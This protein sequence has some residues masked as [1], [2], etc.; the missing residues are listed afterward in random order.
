MIHIK[1]T[2]CVKHKFEIVLVKF[3]HDRFSFGHPPAA[4]VQRMSTDINIA[5]IKSNTSI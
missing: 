2:N 3:D 4:K 1:I 5:G